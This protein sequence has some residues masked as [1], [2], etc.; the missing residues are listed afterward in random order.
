MKRHAYPYVAAS[1]DCPCSPQACGGL[2]PDPDCPDHGAKRN[3]AME[4]HQADS[5]VC[6]DGQAARFRCDRGHPLPAGFHP[7]GDP[8]DWDD[9][10]HCK[11]SS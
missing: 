10:C 3:P 4:W 11:P 2:I 6:V 9:T 8:D 5:P 1:A 7:H